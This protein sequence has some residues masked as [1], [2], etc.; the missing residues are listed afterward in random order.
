M[1][2]RLYAVLNG[3]SRQ[4]YPTCSRFEYVAVGKPAAGATSALRV[5]S[6]RTA[7]RPVLRGA[8]FPATQSPWQYGKSAALL[9]HAVRNYSTPT[10]LEHIAEVQDTLKMVSLLNTFRSRGH[11]IARLDPLGRGLGPVVK[12]CGRQPLRFQTKGL[13]RSRVYRVSLGFINLTR[14]IPK[15]HTYKRFS[16]RVILPPQGNQRARHRVLSTM[17]GLEKQEATV[18]EDGRD[19][20]EFLRGYPDNLYINGEK[21]SPQ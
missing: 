19:L 21:V 20:Y 18:P 7:S 5:W 1:A 4:Q 10:R 6:V 16:L 2:R 3:F 17:Q 9:S 14:D 11:L 12:V 8:C 15:V 13:T